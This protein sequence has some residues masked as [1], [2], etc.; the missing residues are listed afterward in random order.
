MRTELRI[1]V[2]HSVYSSRQPSGENVVVEQEAR[3]LSRAG[4]EVAVFAS[5]TELEGS[6]FYASRTFLR[7]ATGLP[8]RVLGVL[9]MVYAEAMAAGLPVRAWRPNVVADRVLEDGPGMA[10]TWDQD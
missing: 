2:M 5:R 9:P 1:A 10:V 4:H 8:K 6:P 3:A 7:V